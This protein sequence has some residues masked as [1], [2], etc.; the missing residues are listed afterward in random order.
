MNPILLVAIGG[1]LGSLARYGLS[2]LVVRQVQ[3]V[4]F[5]W[6]TFTVNVLGCML[7]G[8]FLLIAEQISSISYEARLF[9]VTGL[10][11]GFT[12]FSAFG[13]ET[14]SLLRR[15]ELLIALS[16]ASLSVIVGV[17]AMWLTYSTIKIILN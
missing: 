2:T 10:L 12:T 8:V 13:I 6:G 11:G 17:A 1:A 5:P 9:V 14:L 7:A 16:Y 15:G 4:H 3:P